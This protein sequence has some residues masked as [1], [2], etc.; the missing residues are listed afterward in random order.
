MKFPVLGVAIVLLSTTVAAEDGVQSINNISGELVQIRQEIEELHGQINQ[1]KELFSD[2]VRSLSN[3]KTDLE[4]RIGRAELNIKELQREL[5]TM[6]QKNAEKNGSSEEVLPVLKAAIA[7]LRSTVESDLPFKRAERLEAL[8]TIE[9][10]LTTNI[11]SPNK[12]A[13]Q[14]WAFVE[15]ELMLGKTN[16]IYKDLLNIDGDLKLVK[17]LRV[18]KVA[19]FY[20]T[21]DMQYGVVKK[22]TDGWQNVKLADNNA[23]QQLDYLFDSFS[24]NIRNGV[25]TVPNFLPEN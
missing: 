8:A 25:F 11:I 5:E 4:V 2:K 20:R 23:V 16:G 18:G 14:L 12:A 1:E 3:Q 24:K 21:N 10:R 6:A 19:M 22:Q 7:D 15:D 17:V 13:N 9:H